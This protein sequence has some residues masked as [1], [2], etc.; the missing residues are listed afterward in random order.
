VLPPAIQELNVPGPGLIVVL[1]VGPG[2]PLW[3]VARPRPIDVEPTGA[4]PTGDGDQ[5][6]GGG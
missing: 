1:I 4:D 3:R 2:F 5:D 6:P